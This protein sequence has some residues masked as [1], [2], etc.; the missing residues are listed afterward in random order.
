MKRLNHI[1]YNLYADITKTDLP[2]DRKIELLKIKCDAKANKIYKLLKN[3]I[4]GNF[5][6]CLTVNTDVE[7]WINK[8][9]SAE[10]K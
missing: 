5:F 10:D 4:L 9:Q 8:L 3:E 2:L 1:L 7:T 6:E